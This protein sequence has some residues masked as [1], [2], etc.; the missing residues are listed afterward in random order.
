[1]WNREEPRPAPSVNYPPHTTASTAPETRAPETKEGR[2][3]TLG[4]SILIKGTLAGSEDLTVDGRVEGRIE[5]P[6]HAVTIGP[7]AI[8]TAEIVAKVV[9][10]FGSVKGNVTAQPEYEDVRAAARLTG[11]PVAEVL[12]EARRQS[13]AA[14]RQVLPSRQNGP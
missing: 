4:S 1:M 6:A 7:N 13:G 9:T 10:V 14:D 11:R 12:A 5:V 8:I 3:A 2:V